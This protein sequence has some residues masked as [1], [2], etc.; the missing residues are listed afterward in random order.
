VE[1]VRSH[2]DFISKYENNPDP[3]NRA[4]AFEKMLQEVMLK[5]RKEELE[6]YKLFAN[7]PAFKAAWQQSVERFVRNDPLGRGPDQGLTA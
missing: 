4:I 7:D 5:R 6:L 2:P 1:S 3:D